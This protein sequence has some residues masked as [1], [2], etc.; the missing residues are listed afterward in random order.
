MLHSKAVI[1]LYRL[2][3]TELYD[4]CKML[5][6][7]E[8]PHGGLAYER[9]RDLRHSLNVKVILTVWQLKA[10]GLLN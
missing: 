6:H 8:F 2:R 4:Y 1:A 5:L 3:Y 7:G 9:W 10:N